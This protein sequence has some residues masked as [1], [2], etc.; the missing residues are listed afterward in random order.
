MNPINNFDQLDEK[1]LVLVYNAKPAQESQILGQLQTLAGPTGLADPQVHRPGH[2]LMV[3]LT[4][5][6]A[7]I[8]Q[9]TLVYL[10][11]EERR[12]PWE[13]RKASPKP[14]AKQQK[15]APKPS[16]KQHKAGVDINR[17]HIL[18]PRGMSEEETI[19]ILAEYGPIDHLDFVAMGPKNITYKPSSFGIAPRRVQPGQKGFSPRSRSS[20]THG[21]GGRD[22]I[23]GGRHRCRIRYYN[24]R[25]IMG[26]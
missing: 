20:H 15:A 5:R 19:N 1:T 17:L 6:S 7:E 12:A 16:A 8:K 3:T 26:Y 9:Q 13:E 10:L 21:T 22:S 2:H 14:S 4:Y 18:M 25:L 24:L 23:L 11:N